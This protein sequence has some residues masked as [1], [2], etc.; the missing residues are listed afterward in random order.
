MHIPC[1]FCGPRDSAEFTYLGDADFRR[2][3][4]AAPDAAHSF[5]EAVYLRDNPAGPHDEYWYHAS[6]CR[7]WLCI[8][9]DT[10]T[11]EILAAALAKG[12]GQ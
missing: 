4:A 6:G 7:S 8:K 1:P 9:R 11:H 2:P 5:V 3:D 10:R 12:T